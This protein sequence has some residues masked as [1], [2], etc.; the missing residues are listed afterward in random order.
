MK[1]FN[2]DKIIRI[3]LILIIILLIVYFIIDINDP[4]IKNLELEIHDLQIELN[5]TKNELNN[6]RNNLEK[7]NSKVQNLKISL[8][9]DMSSMRHLGGEQQ[10]LILAEIWKQAKQYKINPAFLYAVL[11]N[12]SRFRNDVIHKPVYVKALKKKIQALGMGGIVWDFWQDRLKA[13]TSLKSKK[14][15]KDWKKNIEGTAY[16]LSYLKSL[17]KVS[18]TKNKYESAS[19]RYYGKYHANYVNKTM[20]K[21]TEL[22]S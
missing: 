1:V 11:W 19:S 16:I 21:F 10:S 6:T 22:T 13:N 14:D 17:P 9:N 20:L 5:K 3:E 7:L 12:E 15:L 2:Y 18:N 4:K 8:V